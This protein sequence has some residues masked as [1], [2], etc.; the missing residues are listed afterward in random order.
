MTP[1]EEK[2][3]RFAAAAP[4]H[5][6]EPRLAAELEF[7]RGRR[8][9]RAAAGYFAAT[10]VLSIALVAAGAALLAATPLA[11]PAALPGD[12]LPLVPARAGENAGVF[13]PVAIA[14]SL[15]ALLLAFVLT[16]GAVRSID[17]RDGHA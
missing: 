13:A 3:A 10:L 14:V 17:R 15:P 9:L 7:A 16:A 2:L 1:A 4:P 6:G 5:P 11:F 8:R 12:A